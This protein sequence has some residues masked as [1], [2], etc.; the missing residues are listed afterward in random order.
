M[1]TAPSTGPSMVVM[2]LIRLPQP[3]ARVS[4]STGTS[5]GMAACMAGL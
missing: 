3:P 4:I 1:S 2:E 5:M